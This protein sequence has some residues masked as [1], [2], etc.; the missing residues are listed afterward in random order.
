[1]KNAA[2]KRV[3]YAV[4]ILKLRSSL[5]CDY[6]VKWDEYRKELNDLIQVPLL[7]CITLK[8]QSIA[9]M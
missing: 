3:M 4:L 2:V 1:M 9:I 5:L 6:M 7:L 8:K